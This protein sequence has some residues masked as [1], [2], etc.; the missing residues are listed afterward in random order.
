M[1]YL[2][3]SIEHWRKFYLLTTLFFRNG[4]NSNNLIEPMSKKLVQRGSSYQ[5]KSAYDS[6][7]KSH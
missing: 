3:L 4:R 5:F 1:A 7:M 2:F 6:F